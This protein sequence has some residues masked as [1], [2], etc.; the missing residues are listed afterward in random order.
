MD[1]AI[2]IDDAHGTGRDLATWLGSCGCP[3]TV[4][5]DFA[6]AEATVSYQQLAGAARV[7]VFGPLTPPIATHF[8]IL[9][10]SYPGVQRGFYTRSPA[11][12]HDAALIAQNGLV[13]IVHQPFASESASALGLGAV[14]AEPVIPDMPAHPQVRA[15][16]P[17]D[18]AGHQQQD[19]QPLPN[20]RAS[21]PASNFAKVVPL[22]DS[23]ADV[24]GD[25]RRALWIAVIEDQPG[26]CRA[27]CEELA[28]PSV[29]V[30][31]MPSWQ[32]AADLALHALTGGLVIGPLTSDAVR[33]CRRL[34]EA[35]NGS[36]AILYTESQSQS[37]DA[38]LPQQYGCL[39]IVRKPFKVDQ[40]MRLVEEIRAPGWK[41]AE[42]QVPPA[43]TAATARVERPSESPGAAA[44][45]TWA[46]AP[47]GM[48]AA[49]LTARVRS[50]TPSPTP[51]PTPAAAPP[52]VSGIAAIRARRDAP[53]ADAPRAEVPAE[54][55]TNLAAVTRQRLVACVRCGVETMVPIG[56]TEGVCAACAR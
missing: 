11:R 22:A 17:P 41:P 25:P 33:L 45:A 38:R 36:Q 2:V 44:T 12:D 14:A 40:V 20:P 1:A 21:T 55:T 29:M 13:A 43:M 47:P 49:P 52:P 5:A 32:E 35:S 37:Q 23:S 27:I 19:Q 31:M 26:C 3:C 42:R 51:T 8:R 48:P 30:K 56:R 18:A 9:G 53:K 10:E 39:A 16:L 46:A 54:P 4:V 28:I 15:S 6:E 50:T 34:Q 7:L 24:P